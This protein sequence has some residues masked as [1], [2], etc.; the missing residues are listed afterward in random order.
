M[1]LAEA[2]IRNA[3]HAS[4]SFYDLAEEIGIADIELGP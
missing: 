3:R 1:N 2:H 4:F